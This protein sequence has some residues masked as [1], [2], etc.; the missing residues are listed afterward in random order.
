MIEYVFGVIFII[1]GMYCLVLKENII[2]KIMGISIII[3]AVHLLLI[4][5]GYRENGIPPILNPENIIN[6]SSYSVDPLVQALVLTSIVIDLS[7]TALA[8]SMVIMLYEKKKTL[9]TKKMRL[10]SG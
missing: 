10:L 5:I 3:M 9:N 4:R 1:I 2:K 6:F 7:I 8:L